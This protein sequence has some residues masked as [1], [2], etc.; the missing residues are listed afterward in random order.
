MAFGSPCLIAIFPAYKTINAPKIHL[1]HRGL[2]VHIEDITKTN[3][4]NHHVV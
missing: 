1:V 3:N 4:E 2:C